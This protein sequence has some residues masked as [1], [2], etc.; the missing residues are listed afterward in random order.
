MGARAGSQPKRPDWLRA[1]APSGQGYRELRTLVDRLGL[2]TVCQSAACPNVG[3]CWNQRTA[4]FLLLGGVCTRRCGFCAVNKGAPPPLDPDEPE[5]VAEAVAA[6]GLRYAVLTSVTRD[7][8]PDGGAAQFA[9]TIRALRARVPGCRVEVLIPDFQGSR[10]ALQTVLEA[11]P[12]VL[13]HN[14]ETVPRLYQEVRPAASYDRSLA[15]LAQARAMHPQAPTKS[16]LMLGLGESRDEVLRVMSDLRA[17]G[18]SL[19][20]LG[21][22]LQPSP[23]HLPIRRFVAPREFDELAVQGVQLGFAH[24]EAGPL[25]RSSYHAAQT[26]PPASTLA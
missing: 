25:V 20:T 14:L 7:D 3:D 10:A 18:V 15:L 24:V 1:R 6:L 2:H 22:Y 21:Q 19:L 13:N 16:G 8:L 9:A 23:S 12:E 26:A 17:V 11:A 4:T 5:R